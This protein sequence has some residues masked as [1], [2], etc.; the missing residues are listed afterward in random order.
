[1]ADAKGSLNQYYPM[2]LT[3]ANGLQ[4][5]WGDLTKTKYGDD[6]RLAK[7]VNELNEKKAYDKNNAPA[8]KI[9]VRRQTML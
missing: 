8:S 4:M 9:N 6:N 3:F 2:T 7:F 1:M 5:I